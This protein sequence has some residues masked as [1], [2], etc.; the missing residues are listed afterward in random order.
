[1]SVVV[2]VFVLVAVVVVLVLVVGSGVVVVVL[3]VVVTA[4][5]RVDKNNVLRTTSKQNR[6]PDETRW[7]KTYRRCSRSSRWY[8]CMRIVLDRV[9]PIQGN[10]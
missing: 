5:D 3:V 6:P 7:R 9:G 2:V 1:M 4:R 10:L 8:Q